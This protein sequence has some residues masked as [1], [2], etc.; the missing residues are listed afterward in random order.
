VSVPYPKIVYPA[1][2]GTP[3]T[4][5][6]TYPPVKKAG[7]YPFADLEAVGAVTVTVS[8]KRQVWFMRTDS[9]MRVTLDFVPWSDMP[10]WSTFI[11]WAQQGGSFLYYPDATATACD[12]YWLEDT[13]GSTRSSTP[14]MAWNPALASG[15]LMMASFEITLRKVPG[16]IHS[17]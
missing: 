13:N 7:A 8:G 10:A 12:E 17:S 9:L 16:G 1:T 6:F 3:T 11:A 5:N 15:A 4:L 14:I 2:G